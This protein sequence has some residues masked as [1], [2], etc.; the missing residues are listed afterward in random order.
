VA[1]TSTVPNPNQDF[2]VP[3]SMKDDLPPPNKGDLQD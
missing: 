1:P 3:D 2:D